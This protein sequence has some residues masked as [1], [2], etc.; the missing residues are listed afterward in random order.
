MTITGAA[1]ADVAPLAVLEG[2][3]DDR[4][5]TGAHGRLSRPTS[6]THAATRKHRSTSRGNAA[7]A[8]ELAV[9]R[10]SRAP[11][12]D[13]TR[14]TL[15]RRALPPGDALAALEDGLGAVNAVGGAYV[16][17]RLTRALAALVERYQRCR[18]ARAT[19]SRRRRSWDHDA[20]VRV[21]IALHPGRRYRI[22]KV[23]ARPPGRPSRSACAAASGSMPARCH[24]AR[25]RAPPARSPA[26][27]EALR[28]RRGTID[29]EVKRRSRLVVVIAACG[30][31]AR[32]TSARR[33]RRRA[34]KR[35][36][37]LRRLDGRARPRRRRARRL[38]RAALRG[39]VQSVADRL[40]R[41][42]PLARAPRIVIVD[43][44]GTYAAFGDRI[45]I[46]RPTIEKLGSEAE[47]AGDRR[48]RAGARR[49]PPRERR[50]CS[51]RRPT[52][53]GSA[54]AATPRRS[55][56][57]ARSRCSSA[58][59]TRPSA[60][61]R[62]LARGA[63][64][65][66]DE[67]HPPRAEA[68]RAR[69]EARRRPATA[70]RAAPS[71]SRTLDQHGHRPRHAARRAGRR[72]LGDRRARHR[73]RSAG[74]DVVHVDGDLFVVRRGRSTL[75]AY[76]IGAPWARELAATL[77]DRARERDRA[78]RD[79]GRH[80]RRR[81]TARR[82][83]ARQARAR[84]P[85]HA[86]AA[87]AGHAGRRSSS[88]RAARSMIEL[89]RATTSAAGSGPAR[90]HR[91]RAR[92][93]RAACGSRSRARRARRTDRARRCCA[94]PPARRPGARG[95]RRRSDQVRR[96]RARRRRSR[97]DAARNAAETRPGGSRRARG[98]PAARRRRR[99][100][101]DTRAAGGASP[102]SSIRGASSPVL[103]SATSSS[104]PASTR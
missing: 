87:G 43:H 21:A 60:M 57:S 32:A 53:T 66:E 2:T 83:A 80:D 85:Q 41:G 71:C 19:P 26:H 45:V 42:S 55:P 15:G 56:T 95:R 52:T 46:G 86:A 73:A 1:P 44:D 51:G 98:T 100:R 25:P 10:R 65:R 6:C 14:S 30:A 8:I 94:A 103:T 36:P 34:R 33:C 64:R 54:R 28:R 92:R 62:A 4:A 84:D 82:R 7:A 76:A 38:R 24:G 101:R 78:R 35:T 16:A 3:L 50:R 29:L 39:Y 12:H 59:V 17:D 74:D 104:P 48:A 9:H 88:A 99:T 69:R 37:R 11:L 91:R 79:H 93:R 49:R 18:L 90:R 89:A 23:V 70:S 102:R 61:A 58:P 72:R 20:H 40:A 22:G 31:P 77:D 13:R 96:P 68:D 5:R 97:R 67:E 27:R 63:R 75:T 47:L 81:T